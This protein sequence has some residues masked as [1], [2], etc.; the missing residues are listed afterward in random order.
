MYKVDLNLIFGYSGGNSG[1]RYT[2]PTYLKLYD[3]DD[4]CDLNIYLCPELLAKLS[5]IDN[6]NKHIIE[7]NTEGRHYLLNFPSFM[8]DVSYSSE[9]YAD[10]YPG[11][12][13][14]GDVKLGKLLKFVGFEDLLVDELEI[15]FEKEGLL[16]YVNSDKK[17]KY[18]IEKQCVEREMFYAKIGKNIY[19]TE[20]AETSHFKTYTLT[21]RSIFKITNYLIKLFDTD[22][23]TVT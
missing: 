10:K 1:Y 2:P 14:S 19:Y 21:D 20:D 22:G 9:P 13:Y 3:D 12:W 5:L 23:I 17:I 15:L 7:K 16:E 18:T 4:G 11:E 6:N 8:K